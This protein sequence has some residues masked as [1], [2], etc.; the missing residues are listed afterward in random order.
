[1]T[2]LRSWFHA[3]R[4]CTDQLAAQPWT[5]LGSADQTR[6]SHLLAPL[7]DAAGGVVPYPNPMGLPRP[8]LT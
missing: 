3:V 2:D 7:A 5:A 6:L 8:G 4:A 1:M